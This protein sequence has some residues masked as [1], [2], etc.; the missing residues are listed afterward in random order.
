MRSGDL[1][2]CFIEEKLDSIS[3]I[4]WNTFRTRWRIFEKTIHILSKQSEFGRMLHFDGFCQAQCI[5]KPFQIKS[6]YSWVNIIKRS[7]VF[8]WRSM[9]QTQWKTKPNPAETLYL[10]V[11]FS[12]SFELKIFSYFIFLLIT[13]NPYVG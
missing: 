5:V 4:I 3:I 2:Q 10:T 6:I 11:P 8:R 12:Y 7:F 13:R 1:R 9:S